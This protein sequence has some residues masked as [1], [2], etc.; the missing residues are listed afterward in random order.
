MSLQDF[1]DHVARS[2]FGMTAKEAQD[3]RICICCQLPISENNI[4]DGREAA[5]YQ[6]SGLCGPCFKD[7]TGQM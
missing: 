5:E 6:I 2:C 1:K 3:Q 7:C 4:R